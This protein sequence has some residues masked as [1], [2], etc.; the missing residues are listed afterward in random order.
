MRK[1]FNRRETSGHQQ[2]MYVL[3][4]LAVQICLTGCVAANTSAIEPTRATPPL[5][6]EDIYYAPDFTL[7]ALDGTVYQLSALRGQWVILNFW[8]TWCVPCVSEMPALQ[9]LA[10]TYSD[11]L[12]LLAI[13]QRE[14]QTIV[15][16]FVADHHLRFP[17]L[18]NPNDQV[19][20]DY[21][22]ISLPQTLVVNPTGELVYRSF[23]A[24]DLM[25]FPQELVALGLR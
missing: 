24:V 9:T 11:Q 25:T 5:P 4:V 3:C 17:V 12:I 15:S 14:P 13:N 22:V 1:N 16:Q 6:T 23:G 10:D 2:F 8:A 18:M 21:Q 7:T 20:L 19:L